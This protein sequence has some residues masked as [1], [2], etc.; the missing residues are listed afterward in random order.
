M[1]KSTINTLLIVGAAAAALVI[2]MSMRRRRGSS[3][4]AGPTEK[5]T[6]AE[7][8]AAT[9]EPGQAPVIKTAKSVVDVI[10]SIKRTPEAKAAAQKRKALKKSPKAKAAVKTF[11]SMPKAVRGIDDI[12][13]LY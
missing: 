4:E 9:V 13:V 10:K 7:F 1:K 11:L 5:I 8:E 6:E 2:F 3:V 12:S